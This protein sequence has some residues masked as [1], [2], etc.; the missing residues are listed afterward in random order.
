[1]YYYR[2]ICSCL[3]FVIANCFSYVAGERKWGS[4]FD[5]RL[6][7]QSW[8]WGR[9]CWWR[10]FEGTHVELKVFAGV[11]F[12]PARRWHHT[13]FSLVGLEANPECNEHLSYIFWPFLPSRSTTG[14]RVCFLGGSYLQDCQIFI[15]TR[16]QILYDLYLDMFHIV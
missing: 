6:F 11:K 8:K 5:L 9:C 2:S 3:L 10:A 12:S 1:M 4:P 13:G 14:K 15:E 16:R 7:E